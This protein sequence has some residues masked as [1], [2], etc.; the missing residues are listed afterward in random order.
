LPLLFIDEPGDGARSAFPA[1]GKSANG[2]V[3]KETRR[4]SGKPKKK[5]TKFGEQPFEHSYRANGKI[6]CKRTTE[7]INDI[8]MERKE[9]FATSGREAL[10]SWTTDSRHNSPG[11][12][13]S[14]N[15]SKQRTA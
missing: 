3:T 2:R 1:N 8:F 5:R 7:R 15:G 14:T 6:E 12:K 10:F 4:R 11:Y 13:S 9:N